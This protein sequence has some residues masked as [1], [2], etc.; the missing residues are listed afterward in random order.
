[1]NTALILS[2]GEWRYLLELK[3]RELTEPL[4]IINDAIAVLPDYSRPGTVEA[5]REKR[6]AVQDGDSLVLEPLLNLIVEE[7]ALSYAIEEISPG[8]YALR[9][10][11]MFLLFMPYE[12]GENMWRIAAFRGMVELAEFLGG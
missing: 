1:M 12:W 9:C 5:L 7:A 8:A 10:P 4:K 11:N 2:A 6:L 3:N